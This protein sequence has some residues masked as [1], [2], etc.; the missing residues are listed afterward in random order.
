MKK[1][2]GILLVC[3]LL[4]GCGKKNKE[5]KKPEVVEEGIVINGVKYE[6][7][8]DNFDY[9]IHYKTAT[10]FKKLNYGNSIGLFSENDKNDGNPVFVIRLFKYKNMTLEKAI[11]DLTEKNVKGEDIVINNLNYHYLKT[12]NDIEVYFH[13]EGKNTYAVTF[14]GKYDMSKM[15]EEF[16]NNVVYE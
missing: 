4:F 11:V 14:V 16:L 5:E 7:D 1:L 8:V 15:K 13:V 9:D 12:D 2:F 6:L 3:L 10:N